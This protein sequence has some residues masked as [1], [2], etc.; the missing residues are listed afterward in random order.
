MYLCSCTP[1]CLDSQW[2]PPELFP[3][4]GSGR[5]SCLSTDIPS[6]RA[7]CFHPPTG[8]GPDPS[9][10]SVAALQMHG[11]DFHGSQRKRW[12]CQLSYW[13]YPL[14]STWSSRRCIRRESGVD[15][16]T[17]YLRWMARRIRKVCLPMGC[18]QRFLKVLQSTYYGEGRGGSINPSAWHVPSRWGI[19][20]I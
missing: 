11:L 12:S 2:K 9:D 7:T 10:S 8:S 15:S 4:N 20:C 17:L 6:C 3:D 14:G 16:G 1:Q 18:S 5:A 13:S 19:R